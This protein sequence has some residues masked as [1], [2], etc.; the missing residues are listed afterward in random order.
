MSLTKILWRIHNEKTIA[1]VLSVVMILFSRTT[2]FA[3]SGISKRSGGYPTNTCPGKIEIAYAYASSEL[4]YEGKTFHARNAVDGDTSTCWQEGAVGSGVGETLTL[5]FNGRYDVRQMAFVIGYTKSN[6]AFERNG[7]P[8][9]INVLFSS[10]DEFVVWLDD[11]FSWQS[12]TLP[13]AV[14]ACWVQFEIAGVY[15]GTTYD[16]TCISEIALYK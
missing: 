11:M 2:V 10:G 12:V 13:Y 4:M 7:R 6:G 14:L 15:W 8:S 1:L 3:D 9:S 16:D 5:V